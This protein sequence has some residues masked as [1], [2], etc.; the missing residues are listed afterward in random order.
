MNVRMSDLAVEAR[1]RPG[2]PEQAA[3]GTTTPNLAIS[4]FSA[5]SS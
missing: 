1:L 4:V 2:P 3:G 5:W